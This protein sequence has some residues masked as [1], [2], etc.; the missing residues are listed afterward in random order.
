MAKN[1]F[2]LPAP[3]GSQ[4]KN[5][6]NSRIYVPKGSKVDKSASTS[7]VTVFRTPKG[8]T[9]R[10]LTPHG[11]FKRYQAELDCGAN[12]YSGEVL[13]DFERGKRSGFIQALGEQSHYNNGKKIARARKRRNKSN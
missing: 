11:K 2:M 13:T 8:K 9:F 7:E 4:K 10:Q 6:S 5:T 3:K 1:N 12:I